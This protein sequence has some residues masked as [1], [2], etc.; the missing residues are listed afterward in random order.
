[1][2]SIRWL[3]AAGYDVGAGTVLALDDAVKA[4]DAGAAFLVSPS[5]DRD[6]IEW[7]TDNAMPFVPGGL[8][9]SEIVSA[10]A[11]GASAVKLFPAS[12]GGPGYLKDIRGPLR[13]IPIIPTGGVSEANAADYL[14]AG[15]IA[16][17]VGGWLTAH[18]DVDEIVRRANRLAESVSAQR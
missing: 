11:L 1:M 5:L 15:A 10:W 7:A 14:A 6:L 9:P 12:L 13:D 8:T 2:K 18:D 3:V 16:V 4:R 17:G